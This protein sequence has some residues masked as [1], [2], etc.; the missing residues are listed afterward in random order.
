[1]RRTDRE[2]TGETEIKAILDRAKVLHLGMVDGGRPYV[3]PLHYGFEWGEYGLVLWCHGAY[4]G[5]KLD[6][7]RVNPT[8]FVEIDCDVELAS[9]G[10]V[11]CRWG[12]YYASVMGDGVASI[13]EDPDEKVRGLRCLMRT[14]TGRDFEVTPRMAGS[15]CVLRIDV[16]RVSAKARMKPDEK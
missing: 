10:D 1:M 8:V 13:V 6:V 9:G 16:P 12:S 7:L 5:R 3:V 2:V 14:Q 15:V 11:A 4:K